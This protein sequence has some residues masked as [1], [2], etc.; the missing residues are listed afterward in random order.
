MRDLCGVQ[1]IGFTFKVAS[2]HEVIIGLARQSTRTSAPDFG[3]L[4]NKHDD[5]IVYG[6]PPRPCFHPVATGLMLGATHVSNP[7]YQTP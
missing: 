4:L 2:V 7:A 1:I 6:I 5:T 3:L